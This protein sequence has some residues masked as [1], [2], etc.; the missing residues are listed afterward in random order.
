MFNIDP[1]KQINTSDIVQGKA[2]AISTYY[3][4][5][6]SPPSFSVIQLLLEDPKMVVDA[7][8]DIFKRANE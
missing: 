4:S 5:S 8:D 6:F 3:T 1:H 7:V 2:G